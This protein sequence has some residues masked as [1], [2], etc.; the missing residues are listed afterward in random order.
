MELRLA[1]LG[2]G[3]VGRAF[4]R[5]LLRKASTLKANYDL[6]CSVVGLMTGRHGG[7]VD[8][9][10]IDLQAALNLAESGASLDELSADPPP[11]DSLLLLH[12]CPADVLIELTPINLNDGEPA[13]SHVRTA[14]EKGMHVVSANKGPLAFAYRELRDLAASQGRAFLFE[15]TVMDGAPVFGVARAGLPAAQVLGFRGVLNSTT[16][17]I[18]TQM[19]AGTSFDE[20]VRAAQAMGIAETDPSADIDGWDATVKTVV[21][22]NA[23]LGADLRPADVDRTGIRGLTPEALQAARSRGRRVKLVCRAERQ[24]SVGDPRPTK[25][26]ARVAP[27]EV[28]LDDPLASLS[29]T[30]SMVTFYT[31]T[32]K[33]LSLIEFEPEPAQTAYG[34]L[35]DLVNLARGWY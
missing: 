17:Y 33:Q 21:L 25:V 7:A 14:L 32:L 19:E 26:V 28:P 34:L 18:L 9:A 10:G 29:G 22:A 24:G 8:P 35:A 20:A 3:N 4:A 31:D 27:E 1:I 6:T 30:S 12:T 13:I 15:S 2:F 16:N 5:L 23:L 11:D